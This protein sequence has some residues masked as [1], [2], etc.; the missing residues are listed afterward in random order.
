MPSRA[1]GQ[2][3]LLV[4]FAASARAMPLSELLDA[5]SR[6]ARFP[7]PT[8]AD[9]GIER[10]SGGQTMV[11]QAVMIGNGRTIYVET[12]DGARALVRPG[13]ILVRTGAHVT[14]A[15]P[16]TRLAGSDLLLEDFVVFTPRLLKLPQ[17]S[18]EQTTGIVLTGAPNPPSTR[19][20][21]VLTIDP[22]TFAVTRT[23]YYEGSISDLAAYR[24]DEEF[25]DVEGH[26]RPTRILVDRSGDRTSTQVTVG[27]RPA[28][29]TPRSLF[30]LSGLRAPSPIAW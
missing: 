22:A 28:P 24:R 16:R 29:D 15:A 11:A 13:K 23:K 1:T 21:L 27:W 20:L 19:A 10:K 7:G 17:I 6:N 4:A 18:D 12:R 30:S 3:L 26:T 9:L 5:T 25:V 8:R 2:A 14:R